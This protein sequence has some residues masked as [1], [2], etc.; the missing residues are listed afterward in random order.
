M[1]EKEKIMQ[2]LN[3]LQNE[4]AALKAKEEV[5]SAKAA[6]DEKLDAVFV[7]MKEFKDELLQIKD[8][9][10]KPVEG[11]RGALSQTAMP[12]LQP[13]QINAPGGMSTE[14]LQEFKKQTLQINGLQQKMK[15]LESKLTDAIANIK[16]GN[17][18]AGEMEEKS[19]ENVKDLYSTI[20]QINNSLSEKIAQQRVEMQKIAGD[21]PKAI[22]YDPFN[23]GEAYTGDF[24][25][26]QSRKRITEIKLLLQGLQAA[27]NS[28]RESV[29]VSPAVD[30]GYKVVRLDQLL[31]GSGFQ[32]AIASGEASHDDVVVITQPTAREPGRV[33]MPRK[34]MF[35]TSEDMESKWAITDS[36]MQ[37]MYRLEIELSELQKQVGASNSAGHGKAMEDWHASIRQIKEKQLDVKMVKRMIE[38]ANI[39]SAPSRNRQPSVDF[40]SQRDDAVSRATV[41]DSSR[42][43]IKNLQMTVERILTRLKALESSCQTRPAAAIKKVKAGDKRSRCLSCDAG[44]DS[45]YAYKTSKNVPRSDLYDPATPKSMQ[46]LVKLPARLRYVISR[47]YTIDTCNVTTDLYSIPRPCGASYA[48]YWPVTDAKLAKQ[49]LPEA[50]FPMETKRNFIRGA[51]G[52]YYVG[53]D[54]P[55]IKSEYQNRQPVSV[56]QADIHSKQ[57]STFTSET[58]EK[59]LRDTQYHGKQARISTAVARKN[60]QRAAIFKGLTVIGEKRESL[61]QEDAVEGK[62]GQ[63]PHKEAAPPTSG[64]ISEETPVD[65][66]VAQPFEAAEAIIEEESPKESVDAEDEQ[67]QQ[68]PE[69]SDEEEPLKDSEFDN[70]AFFKDDNTTENACTDMDTWEMSPNSNNNAF[71]RPSGFTPQTSTFTHIMELMT[72]ANTWLP[73]VDEKVTT[74]TNT[75]TS[76]VG[77]EVSNCKNTGRLLQ[78]EKTKRLPNNISD[79]HKNNNARRNTRVPEDRQATVNINCNRCKDTDNRNQN[80][81]KQICISALKLPHYCP[82]QIQ[83]TQSQPKPIT[84]CLRSTGRQRLLPKDCHKFVEK[85]IVN[86]KHRMQKELQICQEQQH[87]LHQRNEE[88]NQLPLLEQKQRNGSHK[89]EGVCKQMSM[90]PWKSCSLPPVLETSDLDLLQKPIE[91]HREIRGIEYWLKYTNNEQEDMIKA[92][93]TENDSVVAVLK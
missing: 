51:D 76:V 39:M 69:K 73:E 55:V 44:I 20:D 29:K 30:L 85:K 35:Q 86:L 32:E 66:D 9:M 8:I 57:C 59:V 19:V 78:E 52:H 4:V 50:A 89:N 63:D 11:D 12:N 13:K 77:F 81:T 87:R 80:A 75:S 43:N 36:I 42:P 37:T 71:C 28:L 34:E 14:Q 53:C 33:E 6:Q 47:T 68:V 90:S 79:V 16:K 22:N 31:A 83:T 26:F 82:V 60:M 88:C 92:N 17:E 70:A 5:A 23:Y 38:D 65:A 21:T 1:E 15:D 7:M 93:K 62:E 74:P 40:R 27:M 64:S 84:N 18:R 49:K 56:L 61:G 24:V 58:N 48:V 46:A 25:D 45:N 41:D 72:M 10:D 3:E 91:K 2:M 54:V 67:P